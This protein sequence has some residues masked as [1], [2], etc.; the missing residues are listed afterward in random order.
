LCHAVGKSRAF[1]LNSFFQRLSNEALVGN[2]SLGGRGSDGVQ[3]LPRQAHVHS[4]TLRLKFKLDRPHLRKVIFGQIRF[5]DEL[6]GFLIASE[7]W[8]FLFHSVRFLSGAC[9]GC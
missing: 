8:Q 3:E 5:V 9:T 1:P 6:F 2:A 7:L 4:F